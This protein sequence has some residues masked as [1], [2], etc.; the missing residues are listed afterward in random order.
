MKIQCAGLIGCLVVMTTSA[1][2]SIAQTA[3][4]MAVALDKEQMIG[5]VGVGCTGIGE[6]KNDARWKAYPIRIEVANTKGDLLGDVAISL[7]GPSG[8]T[9]ATVSCEGPW[10]MLRTPQ[11]SYKLDAWMPGE[12]FKHQTATFTAP[13][14]GQRIVSVRFPAM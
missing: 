11:G 9:L 6:S 2:S 4:P 3:A 8:K 5:D 10:I 13:A 12:S 1:T 14:H 7:S